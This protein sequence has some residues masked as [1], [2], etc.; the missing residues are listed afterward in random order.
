MKHISLIAALLL[1]LVP[2]ACV[3][4]A[5]GSLSLVPENGTYAVG[6]TFVVEV[7]VDSGGRAV[8]AAEADLTFDSRSLA[9]DHLSTDGSLIGSWPTAPIFSNTDGTLQFS[10]WMN[11]RF[12]GS[13]G[14]ILTVT[15]RA[16]TAS[17]SAVTFTSGVLLADEAQETNVLATMRSG[18]YVLQ[19]KIIPA[20]IPA[21][22]AIVPIPEIATSTTAHT[23]E[24]IPLSETQATATSTHYAP[25]VDSQAAAAN[26][27][28]NSSSSSFLIP[29][30]AFAL[31]FGFGMGYALVRKGQ[32]A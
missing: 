22:V 25:V 23:D 19:P 20:R 13:E 26:L 12:T 15:F 8:R 27:S 11:E 21:P 29:L 14:H 1:M 9:I 32:A 28:T 5:D 17:R 24:A 7:V 16:L 31:A 2:I 10:G 6:D 18:L 30:T 3:S 4:A